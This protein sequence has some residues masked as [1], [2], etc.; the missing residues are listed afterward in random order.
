MA[1]IQE[2]HPY[3]NEILPYDPVVILRDVLRKWLLILSV[4]II[5]GVCAF[6]VTE[7]TYE[8]VYQSDATLVVTSRTTTGSVYDNIS[9]TNT[10][11]SVFTEVLNSSVLRSK[12]LEELDLDDFNGTIQASVISNTNLLT[13]KVQSGDPRT[14][15]LVA[16]AVLEHHEIVTYDVV[17]DLA[18]EILQ[19][20]TVP[21]APINTSESSRMQKIAMIAAAI[22][23]SVLLAFLSYTK[24]TVRS[25]REA[26]RKLD[27]WCLGE[28]HHE[29][30][31][32]TI[33]SYLKRKKSSIL[34][35]NPDTSF[36]FVSTIG[37]LRQRVDQ[38]MH[39]GK[40]LMVT[41]VTENEGKST[42]AAN[43][44]LSLAK[45]RGNVLLI[46]CDLHKPACHKVLSLPQGRYYVNDVIN[47]TATLEDTILTEKLYHL[48]VLP[49]RKLPNRAAGDTV[50]SE[51]VRQLIAQVRE[52]FEYVI[53]DLPPMS[54]S[55]DAEY[56]S[57]LVD[58]S[59][60]VVKQNLVRTKAI[61]R[62]VSVLQRGNA[63]LLGCVLNDV[64]DTF[65]SSGEGYD[66]GYGRYGGY[67]KYGKYKRYASSH[68]VQ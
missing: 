7:S 47:G 3:E 24:D 18:I 8:P 29:R 56:M 49:A 68:T 41:S 58:A 61:N 37:K 51:G 36:R 25:R 5:A 33:R 31:H 6:V 16:Q 55:T 54:V 38:H 32:K 40:V 23:V 65:L 2:P 12:I 13:L 19:V 26:E 17:G 53:I 46:D 48:K 64:Y 28:I 42:L 57:E 34:I 60:L 39:N 27:C 9:S 20:P 35:S 63:A 10:L 43:L 22:A 45:K 52:Q 67:G 4:A 1:A 15:F 44:A 62:A 14:A 66:V 11:A 21:M 59:V 50:N 30:K